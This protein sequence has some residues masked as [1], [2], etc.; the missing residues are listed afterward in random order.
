[1]I[2]LEGDSP[3]RANPWE[4]PRGSRSEARRRD[5][6]QAIFGVIL[7]AASF[8]GGAVVNGPGLRWAQGMVMSRLGLENDENPP[9]PP[10]EGISPLAVEPSE[11]GSDSDPDK[12]QNKVAEK[13]ETTPKTASQLD[14]QPQPLPDVKPE[15]IALPVK[16]PA[17]ASSGIDAAVS[18]T[19][20]KPD[21]A[22]APAAGQG[23]WSEIRRSLRDAG[24][25][26]YGIEGEPG[27]KVRFQCVIPLAG[28]RAMSQ[29]FEAGGDDEIQAAR[30]VLKR[31]NLWRAT[32]PDGL[33]P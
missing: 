5:R 32:E 4:E 2:R 6:A 19:S 18:P 10:L 16:T 13:S 7:V 1:M 24:V 14:Q 8:A 25:A 29:H 23:D 9:G 21:P 27:G 28:R 26:R 31:I 3:R 11:V 17:P 20:N 12:D 15:P 33:Q 30:A 22:P